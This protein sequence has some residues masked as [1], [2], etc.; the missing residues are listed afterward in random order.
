MALLRDETA[1][2]SAGIAAPK[3]LSFSTKRGISGARAVKRLVLI[4]K[5]N[6][7]CGDT[8]ALSPRCSYAWAYATT[9]GKPDIEGLVL[10]AAR[11]LDESLGKT[12]RAYK[13]STFE[14]KGDSDGY[15]VFDCDCYQAAPADL[16]GPAAMVAVMTSCFYV[17][18]VRRD[19]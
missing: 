18:Y 10:I 8:A 16:D 14:T 13:F 3:G 5:K 9:R 6:R 11:L 19:Y 1:I 17:G 12:C 2:L 15:F 7:I 4:D